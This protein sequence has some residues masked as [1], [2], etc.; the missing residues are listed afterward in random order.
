MTPRVCNL[1][2]PDKTQVSSIMEKFSYQMNN[3]VNDDNRKDGKIT[4]L[5]G[6][7]RFPGTKVWTGQDLYIKNKEGMVFQVEIIQAEV[8]NST[9]K[10]I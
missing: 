10:N 1:I 5:R 4:E 2:E 6:L 8:L 7:S 3:A 9:T